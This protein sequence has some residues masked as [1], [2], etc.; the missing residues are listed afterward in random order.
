MMWTWIWKR[1]RWLACSKVLAK[2][3]IA[4]SESVQM[5]V[6][7]DKRDTRLPDYHTIGG[8]ADVP[9]LLTAEGKPKKSSGKPHTESP[10]VII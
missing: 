1:V 3:N 5:G 2:T 4:L 10:T 6:R 8:G 7:I 9:M